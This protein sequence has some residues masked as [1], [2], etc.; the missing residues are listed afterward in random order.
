MMMMKKK[1]E[2]KPVEWQVLNPKSYN[3]S[4]VARK[5]NNSVREE[6]W[7]QES[8]QGEDK[9]SLI[10]ISAWLY[11]TDSQWLVAKEVQPS[12]TQRKDGPES[13][14]RSQAKTD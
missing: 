13:M 12:Y 11:C 14:T 8:K 9:L 10:H 5:K 1:T 7:R 4:R 6:K 3:L 2:I